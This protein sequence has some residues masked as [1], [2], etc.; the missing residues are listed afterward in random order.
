MLIAL[1]KPT[2]TAINLDTLAFNIGVVDMQLHSEQ[3]TNLFGTPCYA[4]T[5]YRSQDFTEQVIRECGYSVI[6]V[7]LPMHEAT[8]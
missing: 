6:S 4:V 2:D 5:S 7:L 8:P 1:I 3:I